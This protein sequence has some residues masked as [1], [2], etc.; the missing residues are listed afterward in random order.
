MDT[1]IVDVE[2][3]LKIIQANI[4]RKI[5]TKKKSSRSKGSSSGSKGSSKSVF[6][7]DMIEDDKKFKTANKIS[8]FLK[9]K[10]IVNK[11]TL[12]NRVYFLNYIKNNLK[13]VKDDDC[14]EK[15]QFKDSEGYT[16]RNII[17]L[18]KRISKDNFNGEI[19]KTSVKNSLGVF[20]IATKVMK[21][22]ASNLFEISLMNKITDD[23]IMKKLSKHFLII[24]RSCLCKKRE[25]SEKSSLISVNEIANGDLA[26]LLNNPEIISN[27]ELLYNILFQT[28]ISIATFHNLLSNV[29]NDC[30]GGNFLWHYNNEKGYYHY[31]FNGI[32]IYLKA[33]KYNIMIYDFGLFEKINKNNSMNVIKDYCEIIPT[34]LNENYDSPDIDF[35]TE[36]NNIMIL[37]MNTFKTKKNS[38]LDYNESPK[39]SKSKIQEDVFN[40]LFENVFIKY[41][42]NILKTEVNKTMKIINNEPYYI[43]NI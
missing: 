5:F 8:K 3:S 29:H 40:I 24:Y 19:Y 7:N 36:M 14:L 20:P 25:I 41:G 28:F 27:N 37:L 33:C 32:N 21:T 16:I 38:N 2:K 23:I 15:K 34:F 43:N 26:T 35:K 18:E 39:S 4:R 42:G 17:N 22:N 1:N 12:N 10:L 31:I 11:Y 30:H 6:L 9:S 13:H